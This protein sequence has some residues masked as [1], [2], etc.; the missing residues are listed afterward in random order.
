MIYEFRWKRTKIRIDS[1][2]V[3]SLFIITYILSQ[4]VFPYYYK[5]IGKL[6]YIWMGIVGALG[7]YTM[8][9]FH[10]IS[11][12]FIG[13]IVG[14]PAK[15]VTIFLLGGVWEHENSS[16][17]LSKEFIIIL[18][19]FLFNLIIF[20]FFNNILIAGEKALWP[21][22]IL[23]L[24]EFLRT[25][26][27][28]FI[29]LN[30]FPILPFD[31]GRIVRALIWKIK[32]YEFA[33]KSV[34]YISTVF[35]L[36]L[37]LNGI[38]VLFNGFIIGGFCWIFIG[39][40][41]QRC[42]KFSKKK[43]VIK[44]I[45]KGEKIKSI[46]SSS[47]VCVPYWISLEKFIENYLYRYFYKLFPV[48]GFNNEIIGCIYSEKVKP[49]SRENLKF[50]CVKEYVTPIN[51][52]YVKACDD[53]WNLITIM[54]EKGRSRFLVQESRYIVGVVTHKDLLKYLAQKLI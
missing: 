2:W 37:I 48:I 9:F 38:I 24:V 5:S 15:S 45:L 19:G 31:S 52:N 8:I 33:T 32:S 28:I 54:N 13:L 3:Y 30:L 41:L 11:K 27:G 1:S 20:Q 22:E 25:L 50:R 26:N 34:S 16:I 51:E 47:L 4:E 40:S 18:T 29:I 23:A 46:M 49:V 21:I 7:F 14:K 43:Y 10:E 42:S 44:E 35:A 12:T 39:L 17:E 6:T 36:L 53:I